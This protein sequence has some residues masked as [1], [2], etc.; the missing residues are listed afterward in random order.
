MRSLVVAAVIY[1]LLMP[2]LIP[3]HEFAHY[4]CAKFYGWNANIQSIY[5]TWSET[6]LATK[7]AKTVRLH[8]TLVGPLL[9][10]VIALL[11]A[12]VLFLFLKSWRANYCESILFWLASICCTKGLRSFRI[13]WQGSG[14]EVHVSQVLWH[15]PM[16]LN[17]WLLPLSTVLLIA[18]LW[19]HF[20]TQTLMQFFAAYCAGV[21][22][23]A[24][25]IDMVGPAIFGR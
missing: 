9:D 14:D 11:G 25:W 19:V 4:S 20:K 12:C 10:Y 15:D 23:M 2:G 7:P 17:N 6:S 8:C 5:T 13:L 16:L 22:G 24:L 1:F 3:L 21:I 18:L